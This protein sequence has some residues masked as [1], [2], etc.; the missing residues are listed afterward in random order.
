MLDLKSIIRLGTL[1]PFFTE[2]VC[3]LWMFPKDEIMH[4][5]DS[6]AE[7]L[8]GYCKEIST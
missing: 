1:G 4:G 8:C 6:E 3:F 7:N 2:N 5:L